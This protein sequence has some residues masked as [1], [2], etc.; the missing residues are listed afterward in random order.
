[1]ARPP[2]HGESP[3]S[4]GCGFL[5][6]DLRDHARV[7]SPC[8]CSPSGVLPA[9]R[10]RGR[11]R[12]RR[13]GGEAVPGGADRQRRRAQQGLRGGRRLPQRQRRVTRDRRARRRRYDA[14]SR[15]HG[16]HARPLLIGFC[17]VGSVPVQ[18]ASALTCARLSSSC[19][20]TSWTRKAP[21]RS[22]PKATRCRLPASGCCR[23]ASCR[24]SGRGALPDRRSLCIGTTKANALRLVVASRLCRRQPDLRWQHQDQPAGLHPHQPAL[25]RPRRRPQHHLPEPVPRALQATR[26]NAVP[27]I[28]LLLLRC[29]TRRTGWSSCTARP[30]RARRASARPLRKSC[31]SAWRSGTCAT[32]RSGAWAAP[33]SHTAML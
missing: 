7:V 30:A 15:A 25:C 2:L 20:C 8:A 23:R 4:C 24:A 26:G 14:A 12:G 33:I 13:P 5:V 29:R 22:A 6:F 31:P 10:Q 18:A 28:I 16:Q 3:R 21:S 27:L 19:T 11:H 17:A 1:M 32:S 9:Q